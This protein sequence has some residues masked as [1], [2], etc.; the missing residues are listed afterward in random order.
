[1]NFAL[2]FSMHCMHGMDVISH[3]QDDIKKDFPYIISLKPKDV[4]KDVLMN[5]VICY[6]LLM[7]SN[8]MHEL[9][10]KIA[11]K[12]LLGIPSRLYCSLNPFEQAITILDYP[13]PA[14]GLKT[15]LGCV[16]GPLGGAVTVYALLKIKNIIYEYYNDTSNSN[17]TMSNA[18]SKGLKKPVFFT[19]EV[20]VANFIGFVWF[21]NQM[22]NLIPIPTHDG[23]H[24]LKALGFISQK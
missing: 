19:R 18:I 21:L 7:G 15:A 14:L 24:V 4:L 6:S 12:L 5:S 10:H 23:Y 16:A 20:T 3:I 1:M 11:F 2:M 17:K 8:Y 22:A 9:S 13:A